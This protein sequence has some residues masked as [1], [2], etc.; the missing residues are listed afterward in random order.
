[1]QHD[2]RVVDVFTA[3]PFQGNPVAVVFE[4]DGLTPAQMQRIA[5]W[6]NLSETT[7]VL[8]P[9]RAGAD[10]RLRIF[11][12]RSELPFAGHPTL[13]SAHALLEAG[14]LRPTAGRVVQDC[15]A[16]LIPI[17]LEGEGAERVLRLEVPAPQ[18]R[19][20]GPA[21]AAD[22][23]AALGLPAAALGRPSLVELGPRW[24]VAEIASLAA[25]RAL[26]PDMAALARFETG[27]AATGVTVFACEGGPAEAIEVRSFAPSGGVDEDPVCGS[28]NGAVAAH[29]L[30]RGEIGPEAGYTA[31]QGRALGRD[32]TVAVALEAGRI[33]IG[34]R[35]VTVV[36]GR[37]DAG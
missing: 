5:G 11:T 3:T 10:Y 23:A 24:V 4:A 22:L 16:G 21:E 9:G 19:D 7:F 2:F 33:R 30:A 27:L 17:T 18:G 32:G 28:G 29:R 15:A 6:T 35:A 36:R 26:A 8:R 20:L 12:P 25:L 1:M 31:R 34:G 13:G 14:V 37:I